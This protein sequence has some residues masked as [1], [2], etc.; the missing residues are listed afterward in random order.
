MPTPLAPVQSDERACQRLVAGSVRTA[1]KDAVTTQRRLGGDRSA[2]YTLE[3]LA[4]V[5]VAVR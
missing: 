5:R 2:R 4:L 1:E 3:P